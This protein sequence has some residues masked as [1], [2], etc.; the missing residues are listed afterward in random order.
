ML[1]VFELCEQAKNESSISAMESSCSFAVSEQTPST[2]LQQSC[3]KVDVTDC[4]KQEDREMSVV[5]GGDDVQQS[6]VKVNSVCHSPP[7]TR[8]NAAAAAAAAGHWL[9]CSLPPLSRYRVYSEDGTPMGS[10]CLRRGRPN[11]LKSGLASPLQR[12]LLVSADTPVPVACTKEVAVIDTSPILST[13]SVTSTASESNKNFGSVASDEDGLT[14]LHNASKVSLSTQIETGLDDSAHNEA[15]TESLLA[16]ATCADSQSV[17]A[18]DGSYTDTVLCDHGYLLREPDHCDPALLVKPVQNSTTSLDSAVDAENVNE[19][20]LE[21]EVNIPRSLSNQSIISHDSGVGLAEPHPPSHNSDVTANRMNASVDSTRFSHQ[22]RHCTGLRSSVRRQSVRLPPNLQVSTD[23]R[24]LLSNAGVPLEAVN[25][26]EN[27]NADQRAYD[28]KLQCTSSVLT[29][30]ECGETLHSCASPLCCV[31]SPS[32]TTLTH[33]LSKLVPMLPISTNLIR[34]PCEQYSASVKCHTVNS[35][36]VG[37]TSSCAASV[38]PPQIKS[39]LLTP[40]SKQCM[41]GVDGASQIRSRF[42]GKPVKRLQSSPFPNHSPVNPLS[43]RHVATYGHSSISAV[44][45]KFDLD[46]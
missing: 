11:S 33:R 13:Y 25:V 26:K 22:V 9:N 4:D 5:A 1:D 28:V 16:D 3:I 40:M 7:A 17:G 42:R 20:H 30:S 8:I 23:V 2:E 36:T 31:D 21:C 37:V 34:V 24:N 14:L 32:T 29:T 41:S 27:E 38:G 10:T 15:F 44:P 12:S 46:V 43:P 45:V 39:A 18:A 35:S 6:A 19:S